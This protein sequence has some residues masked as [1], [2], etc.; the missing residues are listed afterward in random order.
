MF[1]RAD[2]RNFRE[3]VFPE[4]QQV[5]AKHGLMGEVGKITYGMN[6]TVAMV[7]A[8]APTGKANGKGKASAMS[9]EQQD[10]A[11]FDMNA[12]RYGYDASWF[13]KTIKFRDGATFVVCGFRGG[14][15]GNVKNCIRI[16]RVSTGKVFVTSPD[17]IRRA[18]IL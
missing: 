12:D 15:T 18:T 14:A 5:L 1:E 6:L 10:K 13:G 4:I 2:A 8:Q 3:T 9:P 11:M 16:S 7:V 17:N